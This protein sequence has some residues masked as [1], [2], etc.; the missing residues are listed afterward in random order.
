MKTRLKGLAWSNNKQ[1]FLK[2]RATN[3]LAVP[4]FVC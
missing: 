3:I 2:N 1:E 4:Q